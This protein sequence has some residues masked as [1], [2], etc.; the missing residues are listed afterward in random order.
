MKTLYY[1]IYAIQMQ[2]YWTLLVTG[3]LLIWACNT[4]SKVAWFLVIASV[5]ATVGDLYGRIWVEYR[6]IRKELS[7]SEDKKKT[8]SKWLRAQ[9]FAPCRRFATGAAI[10]DTNLARVFYYS[11]GYRWWHVFPDQFYLKMWSA[12]YWKNAL[13]KH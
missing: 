5:L 2:I 13:F 6:T 3:L 4:G 8:R 7:E 10:R 9:K 12:S 11:I 1:W